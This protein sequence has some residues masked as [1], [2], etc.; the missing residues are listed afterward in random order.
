M[1]HPFLL[2]ALLALSVLSLAS[3]CAGRRGGNGGDDDDDTSGGLAGLDTDGDGELTD[4]DLSSG[5][6]AAYIRVSGGDDDGVE[7]ASEDGG[8][9]LV[10]GDGSWGLV[11]EAGGSYALQL[12]L[13][14]EDPDFEDFELS[15]GTGALQWVNVSST[16]EEFLFWAS[17]SDGSVNVTSTDGET[18]SGYFDGVVDITV[19]DQFE[20]PTGATLRIEG[21]AFREVPISTAG[22]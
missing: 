20:S 8:A 22:R 6:A 9:I 21:F 4:A 2:R 3:G 10:P 5:D 17:S 11:M 14:F 12:G 7:I 18:A 15:V 13:Y 19:A 16:S 1:P